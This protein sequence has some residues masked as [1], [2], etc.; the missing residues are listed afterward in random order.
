MCVH[1][2]LAKIKLNNGDRTKRPRWRNGE[3][4]KNEN[5]AGEKYS[6]RRV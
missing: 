2:E 4:Q 3:A 6:A 5:K 1:A